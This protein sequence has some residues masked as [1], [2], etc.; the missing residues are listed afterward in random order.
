MPSPGISHAQ[1][2]AMFGPSSITSPVGNGGRPALL[3]SPRPTSLS[4]CPPHGPASPDLVAS[5]RPCPHSDIGIMDAAR[6]LTFDTTFITWSSTDLPAQPM[7][8]RNT[9]IRTLFRVPDFFT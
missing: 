2:K 5:M 1:R 4:S 6:A 9:G 8:S 3:P 7:P